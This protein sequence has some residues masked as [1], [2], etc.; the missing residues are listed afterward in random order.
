MLQKRHIVEEL[1]TFEASSWIVGNDEN[2]IDVVHPKVT[3]PRLDNAVRA[4]LPVPD[5]HSARVRRY[6]A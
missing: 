2:Q 6:C 5:G 3:V 4:E 1:S